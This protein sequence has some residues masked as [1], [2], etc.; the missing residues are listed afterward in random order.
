MK[1]KMTLLILPSSEDW[2]RTLSNLW[3][4]LSP[5]KWFA[6]T[7]TK[8]MSTIA[9]GYLS[10][11][12][13]NSSKSTTNDH[14]PTHPYQPITIQSHNLQSSLQWTYHF[15]WF[16]FSSLNSKYT[17]QRW[18]L[19]ECHLT[20]L[21]IDIWCP[22]IEGGHRPQNA[23]DFS[24]WS[25]RYRGKK[26]TLWLACFQLTLVVRCLDFYKECFW[27]NSLVYW[28]LRSAF[29]WIQTKPF[30]FWFGFSFLPW[31]FCCNPS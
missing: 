5:K 1:I 20:W 4:S 12:T 27:T 10:M 22:C 14:D 26:V 7:S 24:V 28:H 18:N 11:S 8:S 21:Q 19:H 13:S 25:L 3:K 9:E 31:L 16:H 29:R 2:W 17:W 6:G 23:S 15:T 30:C